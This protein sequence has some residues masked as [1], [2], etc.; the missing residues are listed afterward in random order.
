MKP[1]ARTIIWGYLFLLIVLFGLIGYVHYVL[2]PALKPLV[3]KEGGIIE[4]ASA[5]GYFLAVLAMW[6]FGGW[7]AIKRNWS[8]VILLLAFGSRELDFD[9]RFTSEKIFNLRMY[10]GDE[11]PFGEQLLG[12]SIIALLLFALFTAY[13]R[14][15]SDFKSGLRQ[16]KFI[17]VSIAVGVALMVLSKSLDGLARKLAGVGIHI[18]REANSLA[19]DIEEVF[20]LAVAYIFLC[21]VIA[22][23]RSRR[24]DP[25]GVNIDSC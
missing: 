7:Q 14:Y 19:S 4:T 6:T 10:T 15:G 11:A 9:K 12:L 16:L 2:D 20:E 25:P 22:A 13:K 8:L 24:R 17:P 3:I 23:F 18:S 1:E 5:V 21:C